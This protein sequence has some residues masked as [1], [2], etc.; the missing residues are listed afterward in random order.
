MFPI[1]LA[2][3][4]RRVSS[5]LQNKA[6]ARNLTPIAAHLPA[7]CGKIAKAT[8]TLIAP[9]SNTKAAN[10]LSRATRAGR[11]RRSLLP[12]GSK[13]THPLQ[14]LCRSMAKRLTARRKPLPLFEAPAAQESLV[15]AEEKLLEIA[16]YIY[17]H[18]SLKP[19]S[20]TLFL[21]SRCLCVSKVTGRINTPDEL[22]SS[23]TQMRCSLNGAAPDDDYDFAA[24][25]GDCADHI[26][27]VLKAVNEV[28]RLTTDTDS[29]GLVF[30]TLLR[31][32]F[33]GGEGLGTYLTPEEVVGPMIEMLMS[34]IGKKALDQFASTSR[35][36]FGDIC[37][38]TGRF[39]YAIA[40]RLESNGIPSSACARAA[41]LFDQSQMAVDL[42]RLNFL[43]DGMTPS[44]S[45]VADSL[46]SDVVSTLRGQFLLLATNPPFGANKYRWSPSLLTVFPPVLLEALNLTKNGDT[47]DPAELFFFRNLDL[48]ADSGALAIVLPD[49]IVQSTGFHDRMRLYEKA[50][51]SHLHAAAIV[52]LP[53]STFALGG[54]V[55]KT[56]FLI[57]QKTKR[58]AVRP[59]YVAHASH[60]GFIKR[61]KKRAVDPAGNDL[62]EIAKAFSGG[63]SGNNGHLVECWRNQ[64]SLGVGQ[65]SH[66][67]SSASEDTTP[68]S[69]LVDV[70][71]EFDRD[72]HQSDRAH[73]HISVLDIDETGALNIVACASNAPA[74]PGLRCQSGDL[75]ISCMNPKIW[76]VAIVPSIEG[77]WTCSPEC[78]VLRPKPGVQEWKVFLGLQHPHFSK[79]VQSLAKGTSSSRQRVPKDKVL[80]IALPDIDLPRNFASYVSWRE[81]YYLNRLRES[82]CLRAMQHGAKEFAW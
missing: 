51:D 30:N 60:V 18:T 45:R 32:K 14:D 20:K 37:G 17:A 43:C 75:L 10:A 11:P 53:A 64:E 57:V 82:A 4:Q 25:V 8:S 69:H 21:L 81:E 33:E 55:A 38:G 3:R 12:L 42:G 73:F 26:P 65:L 68:L 67:E 74:T 49:G 80:G 29:L 22:I 59:L 36:Y 5:G 19:I 16:D 2:F 52:S 31:G 39:V 56:S 61:G 40:K 70:V 58:K 79:A 34:S 71:R 41:R 9:L 47:T 1:R 76:R 72:R 7:I 50:S 66:R 78:L 62:L 46:V 63:V 54:T 27:K 13:P 28:C 77:K 44:F 35:R 24:T 6:C 23:Y 48:L 15:C